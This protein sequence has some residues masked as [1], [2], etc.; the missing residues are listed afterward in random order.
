M[1]KTFTRSSALNY[2]G[3]NEMRNIFASFCAILLFLGF[4]G[5]SVAAPVTFKFTGRVI[6]V[7]DEGS[8]LSSFFS[9]NDT[10]SGSYTF[11]STTIDS[12]EDEGHGW[13]HKPY[14]DHP[15]SFKIIFDHDPLNLTFKLDVPMGGWNVYSIS[16]FTNSYWIY[17]NYYVNGSLQG[18]PVGNLTV[19]SFH[20]S[21]L[22]SMP[23]DS[24]PISPPILN[25]P[26]YFSIHGSLSFRPCTGSGNRCPVVKFVLTSLT[27]GDPNVDSDD[28]GTPD[29]I[30]NCPFDP[31][32]I[33]PG[34]CGCGVADTDTDDDGTPDCIDNCPDD[35]NKTEPGICGCGI[36]DTGIDTDG[37]GTYDCN[38]GCPF[39]PNKIVPGACGCG[40]EDIDTNGNGIPDCNEGGVTIYVPSDYP[41][42]Q[43]AIDV[44]SGGDTIIVGDGTYYENVNVAKQIIIKSLNGPELTTVI[45]VDTEDHVFEVTANYVTIQS[46]AIQIDE[47]QQPFPNTS[48]IYLGNNTDYCTIS[49][50]LLTGGGNYRGIT[51]CS[52]NNNTISNN[53]C[54]VGLSYGI[55][56]TESCNNSVSDNTFKDTANRGIQLSNSSENNLISRNTCLNNDRGIELSS[57]NNNIITHNNVN[58]NHWCGIS[59]F[60]SSNNSFSGNSISDNGYGTYFNSGIYVASSNENIFFLNN[61]SNQP[62]SNVYSFNSNN[63]WHSPTEINY[64]YNGTFYTSCLGNYYDDHYLQDS[65]GDGITDT[66]YDLPDIEPD[67]EYPLASTSDKYSIPENEAPVARAGGPYTVD[68]GTA[69]IL[70]GSGS[71]DPDEDVLFFAWDLDNDGEY[72]DSTTKQPVHTWDDDGTYAVGLKV[73]DSVLEDINTTTV[74]VNNVAPTVDV[75]N[76]QTAIENQSVNFKGSFTDPGADT[77]II[78]WNFGDAQGDS[79]NLNTSHVYSQEGIYTVTLTVTDDDGGVGSDSLTIEVIS[80]QDAI[81]QILQEARTAINGLDDSVFKRKQMRNNLNSKINSV[82]RLIDKRRYQRALD[83]LEYGILTKMDGCAETASPDKN[84]WIIDCDAQKQVYPLIVEAIA[85]LRTLV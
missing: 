33:D 62:Y 10:F 85:L 39:D 54:S 74:T 50:N 58:S 68:E 70:D 79:G 55:Y 30:D 61:I 77:H 9:V 36:I 47:W 26:G 41:T 13:Y 27:L 84:D 44:A 78:E 7:D 64:L 72:D 45:A 63:I 6:A 24:L 34:T 5:M 43:A 42:I 28:D 76:D 75:G 29:G 67:D 23:N 83:K 37:D 46:F 15:D 22:C 12:E 82:L 8:N 1:K 56:L 2:K 31:N 20:W 59:I 40:V 11:D 18:N 73:S 38:D 19:G 51:I 21:N 81:T 32:K 66:D 35:P 53:T 71:Y 4:V 14:Y 69:L 3:D 17:Y 49:G 57:S 65:D 52:S 60:D 80:T 25:P 48:G 16:T